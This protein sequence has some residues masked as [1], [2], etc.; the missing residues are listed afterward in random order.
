M[1]IEAGLPLR[2]N[3]MTFTPRAAIERTTAQLDDFTSKGGV[4]FS[5]PKESK[6]TARVGV[7]TDLQFQSGSFFAAMDLEHDFSNDGQSVKLVDTKFTSKGE[8]T[9][10]PPGL[11]RKHC[12]CRGWAIEGVRFVGLFKR[13]RERALSQLRGETRILNGEGGERRLGRV[14]PVTIPRPTRR[15]IRRLKSRARPLMSPR[16]RVASAEQN[17]NHAN[18]ATIPGGAPNSERIG[19]LMQLLSIRTQLHPYTLNIY[20]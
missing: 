5:M 15:G 20:Q 14:P 13:R 8:S 3:G 16:R 17:R 10:L 6:T 1:G 7:R 11:G 9:R 19:G 2:S 4:A 18:S 12:T